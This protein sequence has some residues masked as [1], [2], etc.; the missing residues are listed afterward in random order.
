M[1]IPQTFR[2]QTSFI[3]LEIG[4]GAAPAVSAFTPPF[5]FSGMIDRVIIDLADD[6]DADSAAELGAAL[7]R[8]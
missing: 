4:R 7:R 8:Q 1:D 5:A 2:G 6:Q 3:G